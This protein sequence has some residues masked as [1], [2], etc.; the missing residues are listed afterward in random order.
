MQVETNRPMRLEGRLRELRLTREASSGNHLHFDVY[1]FS[2]GERCLAFYCLRGNRCVAP[3][4]A[5]GDRV[6]IVADAPLDASGDEGLVY[7]LR[8]LED[9]RLYL[10]HGIFRIRFQD[11]AMTVF[12]PRRLRELRLMLGALALPTMLLIAAITV[13]AGPDPQW[14]LLWLCAICFATGFAAIVLSGAIA[15]ALWRRGWVT[16][17]QDL[18]ER[19][20]AAFALAPP[21]AAS[22]PPRVYE[23]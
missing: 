7:A 1:R 16:P 23:V 11:R 5:A 6:E 18:T 21:L 22:L 4:L 3:F 15:R 8:N 14:D 20:Y 17:R 13:F 19:V 10:S 2:L 9:G 12:T